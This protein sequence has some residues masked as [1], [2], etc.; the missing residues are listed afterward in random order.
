M[1]LTEKGI[2]SFQLKRNELGNLAP[3]SPVLLQVLFEVLCR[4]NSL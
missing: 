4:L 3:I 2:L 1:Y